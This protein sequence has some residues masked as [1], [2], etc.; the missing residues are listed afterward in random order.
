MDKVSKIARGYDK[1]SRIPIKFEPTRTP[2]KKPEW[3][4]VKALIDSPKSAA[5]RKT[6]QT[7]QLS[8]VCHEANC[9]NIA[10]CFEA[11]TATFLIMGTKC[12]R[13]CPFCDVGHA[14]PDPLDPTEPDRLAKACKTL[15]LQYV[16][17]TSVDRDDLMDGGASHF[18]AVIQALRAQIPG[19][20]IEIL[21]PD[22][23]GRLENALNTLS[24]APPDVFNH[25]IET[26]PAIYKQVRP[27]A[28]YEHSLRLLSEFK[29]LFP[30]IPTK[31]GVMLGLGETD[32][33]MLEVL[34]D[35]R[36]HHV[37]RLTISQY[38]APSY[39]HYPVQRYV[40]P[41]QFEEWRQI[42]LNLGFDSVISGVFVRS[43]YHAH[44]D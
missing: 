33:Q 25:N 32:D 9:P 26:V 4:K 35:L 24:I 39:A 17:I 40:K 14:R 21:T 20:R 3:L 44:L 12:T 34:Y 13:R 8:T 19:I 1:V 30:H 15:K 31:S 37:N 2:L 28:N 38:L 42:A 22:F 10:E 36:K 6:L 23:R 18:V 11:Q 5:V 41:E 27:G 7:F 16:T 43:S 29:R